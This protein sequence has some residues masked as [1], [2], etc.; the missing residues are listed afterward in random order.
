MLQGQSPTVDVAGHNAVA[1]LEPGHAIT[2]AFPNMR[3]TLGAI[4][5]LEA[6]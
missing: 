4:F 5:Y 2:V 6:G 3:L 1:S